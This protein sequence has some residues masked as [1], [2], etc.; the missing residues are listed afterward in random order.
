[1][2]DPLVYVRAVH[3]AAT[4]MAA[5][6]VIF[7]CLIAAPALA[8]ASRDLSLAR[9]R[10]R[11]RWAWMVWAS[12]AVAVLS[13]AIWLVL[14]AAEIYGGP[15]DEVW[16]NGDVWTKRTWRLGFA[17]S[18]LSPKANIH[19]RNCDVHFVPLSDQARRSKIA[20]YSIT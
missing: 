2:S 16:R 4:I 6:T 3:F 15:V 5:G 9:E 17:M 13:G 14:L 10:L 8:T 20:C 11:S 12:L 7:Q 19:P 1:L 18:A